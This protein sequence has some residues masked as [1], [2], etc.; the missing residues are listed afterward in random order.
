M[1]SAHVISSRHNPAE[2]PLTFAFHGNPAKLADSDYALFLIQKI[3][4]VPDLDQEG[5]WKVT[6]LSYEYNIERLD[7]GQ[8]VICFHWEGDESPNPHPHLHIGWAT[9][10]TGTHLGPKAHIPSGRVSLEH[11][12]RFII[13]DLNV[14]PRPPFA[15][16]YRSLLSTERLFE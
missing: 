13:E 11:V 1:T 6:M 12:L 14:K 7:D 10:N 3:K 2:T 5:S 15:S 16:R 9:T 4:I 8:E